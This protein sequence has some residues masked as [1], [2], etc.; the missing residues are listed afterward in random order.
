MTQEV[1]QLVRR[2]Q[3]EI[4]EIQRIKDL[5]LRRWEKALRDQD[6]LGSVAFDLHG[7]CQGVE[8]IFQ[9]FAK[10]IDG[11]VPTGDAWHKRLLDQMSEEAPGIRPAIISEPTKAALD[12]YRTF[13]HVARNIYTFNLDVKKMAGLI[14]RP[15]RHN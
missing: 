14:E 8:R 13:R 6:Y 4:A 3:N 5:L 10:A 11:D 9:A 1:D 2:I 12:A 15:S 7:F